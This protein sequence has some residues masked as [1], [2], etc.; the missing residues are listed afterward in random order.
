MSEGQEE[1]YCQGESAA[2]YYNKPIQ[3]GRV[4]P[5]KDLR[6]IVPGGGTRR[7]RACSDR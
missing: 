7:L 3:A 5:N 2:G 4:G 6:P 1:Q